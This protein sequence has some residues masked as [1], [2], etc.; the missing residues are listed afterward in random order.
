MIFDPYIVKNGESI[1]RLF[2]QIPHLSD[3]QPWKANINQP[4]QIITLDISIQDKK[5]HVLLGSP[6][7]N[8][9]NI[10]YHIETICS[11]LLMLMQ[12]SGLCQ[13][14]TTVQW[15]QIIHTS[16]PLLFRKIEYHTL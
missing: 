4:T 12:A 13:D 2:V 5:I 1:R 6:D 9:V 8:S 10:T 14:R 3:Q 11:N 16:Q 15:Y 7:W